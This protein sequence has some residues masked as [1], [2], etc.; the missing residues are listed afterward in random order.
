MQIVIK[1]SVPVLVLSTSKYVA[2][3]S[4]QGKWRHVKIQKQG[5]SLTGQFL[6]P[7]IS[8]LYLLNGVSSSF[9]HQYIC[10]KIMDDLA[11]S[12]NYLMPY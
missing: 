8:I 11:G 9:S 4:G 3:L 1:L 5:W 6:Q 12:N 7:M 10:N 2:I